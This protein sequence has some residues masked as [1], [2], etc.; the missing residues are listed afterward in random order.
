MKFL[1]QKIPNTDFDLIPDSVFYFAVGPLRLR[2]LGLLLLLL[3][4]PIFISIDDLVYE[5][6]VRGSVPTGPVA[7]IAPETVAVEN[8]QRSIS[9]KRLG[10]VNSWVKMTLCAVSAHAIFF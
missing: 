1:D 8:R 6:T 5:L 2:T 4:Q 7:H 9:I 3:K 10:V